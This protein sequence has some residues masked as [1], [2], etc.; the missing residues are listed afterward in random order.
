VGWHAESVDIVLLAEL[1][2]LKRLVAVVAIKGKQPTRPNYLTLCVLDKVLQPLNSKLVG[3]PAVVA[4]SDSPV[5]RD[6]L[7][8][9]GRQVVLASK[10][11]KRW[12]SLASSVNSLDY[13]YPL[14]IAWL[15]SL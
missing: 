8:V 4:D 12:D 2:K 13:C 6:I 15:D 11:N 1:L 5:A 3:R 7:L 10:D 9:P 14:V